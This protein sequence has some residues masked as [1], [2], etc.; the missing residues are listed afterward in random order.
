[1]FN[2]N[3]H[4]KWWFYIVTLNYQRV[5]LMKKVVWASSN[6]LSVDGTNGTVE[7]SPNKGGCI[8][9]N[10]TI[11]VLNK[12]YMYNYDISIICLI[13]PH[14]SYC[15]FKNMPSFWCSGRGRKRFKCV[16]MQ[17]KSRPGRPGL[18]RYTMFD[19]L[20]HA[21]MI[22]SKWS[23]HL[24]SSTNFFEVVFVWAK[25]NG[26]F[27]TNGKRSRRSLYLK[28][29]APALGT[30]H[31]GFPVK[32]WTIFR[33]ALGHFGIQKSVFP[34]HDQNIGCD[35]C[36]NQQHPKH[37]RCFIHSHPKEI[38]WIIYKIVCFLTIQKYTPIREYNFNQSSLPRMVQKH[39]IFWHH[40]P[41]TNGRSSERPI[42]HCLQER[43]QSWAKSA[44]TALR[45][46]GLG[47]GAFAGEGAPQLLCR[48]WWG[49]KTF[50]D[51]QCSKSLLVDDF[52]WL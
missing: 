5:N 18:P 1:M 41:A 30:H 33:T 20:N 45:P 28:E 4:Y 17:D 52:M 35:V 37:P 36:R 22:L 2:G 13:H 23:T 27:V 26:G 48:E 50:S 25:A 6:M 46:A 21:Y 44:L 49:L 7:D 3:I 51:E 24:I 15:L 16:E 38:C 29:V 42:A 12:W 40:Q 39:T 43:L 11:L 9:H 34:T 31:H 47:H 14:T 32:Y 19:N 8:T 10:H